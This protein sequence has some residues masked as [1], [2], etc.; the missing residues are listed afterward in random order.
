MFPLLTTLRTLADNTPLKVDPI[1]SLGVAWNGMVKNLPRL[2]ALAQRAA[3]MTAVLRHTE[4][5]EPGYLSYPILCALSLVLQHDLYN[6]NASPSFFEMRG[7]NRG[8]SFNICRLGIQIYSEL[9]FFPLY[10]V[11]AGRRRLAAEMRA[12]LTRYTKRQKKNIEL[13]MWAIIMGALASENTSNRNWYLQ[14][15]NKVDSTK[16]LEWNELTVSL[17]RY[18]WWDRLFERHTRDLWDEALGTRL[19]TSSS[20]FEE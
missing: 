7:E 3:L 4:R 15:I 10:G 5:K 13:L 8:D 9:V 2:A 19:G 18:L 1:S 11:F 16:N 6:Q 12:V 17:T 20:S 14:Q